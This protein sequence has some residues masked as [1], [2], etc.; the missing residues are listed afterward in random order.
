MNN[1]I[2]V[3]QYFIYAAADHHGVESFLVYVAQAEAQI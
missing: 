3:G 1:Y 2:F